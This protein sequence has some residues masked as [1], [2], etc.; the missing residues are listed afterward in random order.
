MVGP[1]D[2]DEFARSVKDFNGGFRL[3]RYTDAVDSALDERHRNIFI[4]DAENHADWIRP[5][6][7]NKKSR[8]KTQ[9]SFAHYCG[10]LLILPPWR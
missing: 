1:G 6:E 2:R 7:Q 9:F 5:I 10:L 4:I 3:V 8:N